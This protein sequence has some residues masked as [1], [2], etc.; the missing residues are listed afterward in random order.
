MLSP[1]I[2]SAGLALA[3]VHAYLDQGFLHRKAFEESK[4]VEQ[5]LSFVPFWVVPVAA[6]TNYTYTDVAVG[7]GSTVGSIAAAELLGSVLGGGRQGGFVPIPVMI[8]SPVERDPGRTRSPARTDFPVVAVKGMTAYQPKDYQFA[9]SERTFFDK[10]QIP[11]GAPVL[12]GDLGEDA[13]QHAARA[14]VMQLQTEAAHKRHHMVSGLTSNIQVSEAELVHVPI[15]VLPPRPEG[16]EGDDPDRFPFRPC[17][18]D[19]RRAGGV[20][21][22]ASSVTP[23]PRG[24]AIA[25]GSAGSCSGPAP[26][27]AGASSSRSEGTAGRARQRRRSRSGSGSASGGPSHTGHTSWDWGPARSVYRTRRR[28]PGG[29]DEERAEPGAADPHRRVLGPERRPERAEERRLR[30]VMADPEDEE[31]VERPRGP[32]RRPRPAERRR[33]LGATRAPPRWPSRAPISSS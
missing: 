16:R 14:Y 11:E 3:V 1:K 6:T 4:V 22:D 13:A 19:R 15:L 28:T 25:P 27:G 2:T 9:L 8:G 32:C 26:D 29:L 18:A 23:H 20:G 5:K 7:V 24:V 12:N 10:K 21:P 17:H 31:P 30:G 33:V